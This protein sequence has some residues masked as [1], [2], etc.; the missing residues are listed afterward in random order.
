MLQEILKLIHGTR[1]QRG[2]ARLLSKSPNAVLPLTV[3]GH[4]LWCQNSLRSVTLALRQGKELEDLQWFLQELESDLESLLQGSPAAHRKE[5]KVEVPEGLAEPVEEVIGQI[6]G[7]ASCSKA[8]YL[9]S[10][11]SFRVFHTNGTF[12]EFR[13]KGLSKRDPAD[14]EEDVQKL[15]SAVMQKAFGFLN[16]ESQEPASQPA[17]SSQGN[18][19]DEPAVQEVMR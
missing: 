2:A 5:A 10:R 7:L 15:F 16:G 18:S 8:K 4:V 14:H 6:E 3:R 9:P 1:P 11:M 13:V 12:E 19:Q 17:Q